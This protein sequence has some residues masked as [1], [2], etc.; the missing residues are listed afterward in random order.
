MDAHEETLRAL[1]WALREYAETSERVVESS[2]TA[3]GVHRTDM[4]TL[5]LLMRRQREGDRTTPSDLVRLLGLT[6]ASA[7]ALVDRL[8]EHGHAERARWEKD[9]RSVT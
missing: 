7:T 4:R 8:V 1:V 3:H 6:S 2:G 5:S 9:R